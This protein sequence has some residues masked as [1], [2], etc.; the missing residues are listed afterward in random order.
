M[1]LAPRSPV[2]TSSQLVRQE[3]LERGRAVRATRRRGFTLIELLVVIA[4]IAGLIALLLPAVQAAREAARRAQCVNNLK[5]MGIALHNYHDQNGSFPLGGVNVGPTAISWQSGTNGLSWRA[6]ILPQL[7]Q[8][9][10]YNALNTSVPVSSNTV[11]TYAGYTVWMTVANVWLCPSDATNNGGQR[12]SFTVDA[13][14]GQYPINNPPSNPATRAPATT[15]PVSNYAGS[16]GDNQVIG[17]LFKGNNPWETPACGT[18]AAG[19]PQI[20]YPG[21]W[22]STYRC[23]TLATTGGS[24]RGFFDYRSG[25]VVNMAG[26]TDG[27][28]SSIMVGEVIP[29]QAADS[30]LYCLNGGTAGVTVPL[31]WNTSGV[32]GQYPG[33][34]IDFG[35]SVWGCRFSP[36][37]K[38]FKSYHPGGANFLFGD[39]SVKFL[40]NSINRIT[41]AAL[42]STRGNEIIGADAY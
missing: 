16:F 8:N 27:S 14:N 3:L 36:A 26:V 41:Y 7:E 13:N 19:Q 17:G 34:T 18:P 39:G 38:G 21:F 15:I 4:I 37:Y 11:N 9:S 33:C 23:D 40:K 12:P 31:N 22:G 1:G 24:L 10:V 28:S 25:Q 35:S 2:L 32:P 5:Q 6:L 30:N 29:Q 20:G 42:G